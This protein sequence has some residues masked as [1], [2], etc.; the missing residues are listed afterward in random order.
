METATRVG[1]ISALTASLALSLRTGLS[2]DHDGAELGFEVD[3]YSER[4]ID[5]TVW[6]I[7]DEG[8]DR[9]VMTLRLNIVATS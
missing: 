7:T 6:A 1:I 2:F 8:D 4:W 9:E 3:D 5:A